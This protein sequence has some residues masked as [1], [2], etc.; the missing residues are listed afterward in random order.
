MPS[1]RGRVEIRRGPMHFVADQDR[2][3][4]RVQIEAFAGVAAA[5][6]AVEREA[7]QPVVHDYG[8]GAHGQ[9]ETIE[10]QD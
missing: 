5:M 4:T 8:F 2:P 10:E 6:E 7:F 1:G 9:G 3:F